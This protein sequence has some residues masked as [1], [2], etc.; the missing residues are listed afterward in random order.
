[1]L[2]NFFR[3]LSFAAMAAA[4]HIAS[5]EQ[6]PVSLGQVLPVVLPGG[7]QLRVAELVM[8]QFY[9]TPLG[10]NSP[11]R[12]FLSSVVLD[13]VSWDGSFRARVTLSVGQISFFQQVSPQCPMA[14][15]HWKKSSP[16]PICEIATGV[17]EV[18]LKV[19][20]GGIAFINIEGG[21]NQPTALIPATQ[22]GK[23]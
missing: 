2:R 19:G 21:L 12:L 6:L 3:S 5:A 13:R 17:V 18:S 16:P 9:E 14:L 8:F 4:A 15:R 22:G 10:Q 7:D 23:G 1:M 11:P 20:E